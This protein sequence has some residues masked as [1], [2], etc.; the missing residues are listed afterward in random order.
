MTA[1]ARRHPRC[2]VTPGEKLK[3]LVDPE[4][5]RGC[6]LRVIACAEVH[7]MGLGQVRFLEAAPA[8]GPAQA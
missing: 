3:A 2:P 7:A 4:K 6:G 5:C 8:Q 1:R